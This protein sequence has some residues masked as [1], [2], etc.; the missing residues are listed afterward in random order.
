MPFLAVINLS[1]FFPAPLLV[2]PSD[3]Q[4]QQNPNIGGR[5]LLLSAQQFSFWKKKKKWVRKEMKTTHLT[6]LFEKKIT[7]KIYQ[8][9]PRSEKADTWLFGSRSE[10]REMEIGMS[11][12][13]RFSLMRWPLCDL[14]YRPWQHS[15]NLALFT[16][17]HICIAGVIQ[18][19]PLC[20]Q[21]LS[22][23]PSSFW[24]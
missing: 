9:R 5:F 15:S 20:C 17:W 19:M 16:D 8:G 24:M 11:L 18:W 13:R 22:C 21:G 2:K 6:V 3:K 23:P 12:E 10:N 4:G 1:S 7:W 14:W